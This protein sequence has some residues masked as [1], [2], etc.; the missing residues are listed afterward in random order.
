MSAL[1]SCIESTTC[2]VVT[3]VWPI[4]RAIKRMGNDADDLA[5]GREHG[6]GHHAHQADVAA[7]V[8]Q[9]RTASDECPPER[10]GG[11]RICRTEP[12]ARP[13]EDADAT[14]RESG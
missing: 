13:A 1:R 11:L 9:A 14:H 4:S 2:I 8:D 12:V 5:A 10:A 7:A 6:I 3:P